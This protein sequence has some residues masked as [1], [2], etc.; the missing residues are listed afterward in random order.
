MQRFSR[1]SLLEA[2]ADANV[3]PR[4][5]GQAGSWAGLG[6]PLSTTTLASFVSALNLGDHK[7]PGYIFD[8]P[9]P[10]LCPEA[11]RGWR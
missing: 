6:H 5:V 8:A 4:S 3:S 10:K 9:L 7:V 2:C 11:L 1:D